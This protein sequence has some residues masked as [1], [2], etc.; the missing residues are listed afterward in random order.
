MRKAYLPALV[1]L[2]FFSGFKQ[3]LN[4]GI[5]DRIHS[6]PLVIAPVGNIDKDIMLFLKTSAE[7]RFGLNVI[8][9]DEI[10]TPDYA[11]DEVKGQ[12]SPKFIIYALQKE[13]GH[14]SN[15][16]IGITELDLKD[17]K[18]KWKYV[19]S[20]VFYGNSGVISLS[21]IRPVSM[22]YRY[23]LI[24]EREIQILDWTMKKIGISKTHRENF[25]RKY[26]KQRVSEESKKNALKI[27]KAV[28]KLMGL[29]GIRKT[30]DEILKHRLEM[31]FLK[32]V[33]G[34]YGIG[35][36]REKDS[37]LYG[38]LT[39]R[40]Q[41]DKIKFKLSKKEKLYLE[42]ALSYEKNFIFAEPD[43]YIKKF[44][45]SKMEKEKNP[46]V[47][48]NY[49]I[50]LVYDYL[51]NGKDNLELSEK[52]LRKAVNK[53]EKN[54]WAW[55]YLARINHINGKRKR[56][57]YCKKEANSINENYRYAHYHFGWRLL[58]LG[59]YKK[60][61]EEFELAFLLDSWMPYL[62]GIPDEEKKAYGEKIYPLIKNFANVI[63]NRDDYPY[64]LYF[65][66]LSLYHCRKYEQS[67]RLFEKILDTGIADDFWYKP[68]LHNMRAWLLADKLERKL[69]EAMVS[70]EIAIAT[71]QS[72]KM[73]GYYRDTRSWILYKMG[74]YDEAK[75]EI[76]RAIKLVPGCVKFHEHLGA[77]KAKMNGYKENRKKA[78]GSK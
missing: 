39:H 58:A 48:T 69:D 71:A 66:A 3:T 40:S 16:V 53:Y 34:S 55:S 64:T 31:I 47:L 78:V 45:K 26:E 42:I 52:L 50:A 77:V 30:Y 6:S 19:W 57:E 4:A 25:V 33:A 28:D 9:A 27:G 11:Y 5:S 38:N 20:W 72:K 49:G 62:N 10:Q 18:G 60:A 61:A 37:F 1:L 12:Y 74:K 14:I 2:L 67:L 46:A 17:E 24:V 76:D 23:L 51:L 22:S 7:K 68:D 59:E 35:E 73:E 70:A 75:K 15:H 44:G 29:A 56:F 32:K 43:A 63:Q 21:R 65:T 41:L 13:Y 8:I 36:S 54:P